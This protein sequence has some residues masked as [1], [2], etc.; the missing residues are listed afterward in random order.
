MEQK[1]SG[2]GLHVITGI[3]LLLNIFAVILLLLAYLSFHTRPS[4]LPYI[5]F[6]GLSYPFI[7]LLNLAFI[8]FWL[9]SRMRYA[10]LS[11]IVVLAGWNHIGRLYQFGG[12][13]MPEAIPGQ[14]KVVSYNLQN[15]LKI[16]TSTTKYVTD[17]ENETNIKK[18]LAEQKAD[19]ICLQEMLHDRDNKHHFA[20]DLARELNCPN[21]HHVNY[22]KKNTKILDAIATFTRYPMIDKGDLEYEGKSIGIFTDLVISSD[23]VRLYNLHL[24][25]IHF[26]QEDY[27][28]WS[29]MT[30]T[31][32]QEKFASGTGK[33]L[34]KMQSAFL[35]RAGQAEMLTAHFNKSPY[36]IIICGDFNDTPSSFAY[37]LL[38]QNKKD[39]FVE[40]GSGLGITY[41]G[42]F[43]PAFRIDFILYDPVYRSHSFTRHKIPY[44]DHY[45]I[46]TYLY[47]N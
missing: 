10:I 47:S 38:S 39:A 3:M 11:I 19:I 13:E 42:E 32:E 9:L 8:A 24:A 44:S 27:E 17:F 15:F 6:S 36:P 16:N 46:T 40:S 5:A 18:F 2:K 20:N 1:R 33:I 34:S 30:N 41:A 28:F 12:N 23:T 7:L 21:Y 45:P 4:V 25:S 22:F 37:N 35:N 26:K 29:D 14:I 43:F 31:Q